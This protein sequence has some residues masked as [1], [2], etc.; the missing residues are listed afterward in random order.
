MASGAAAPHAPKGARIWH[1]IRRQSRSPG[2]THGHD[3]SSTS[4]RRR[5]CAPPKLA[6]RGSRPAL[7]ETLERLE[8]IRPSLRHTTWVANHDAGNPKTRQ[9]E[10]HGHAMVVIGIDGSPMQGAG[11]DEE[12]IRPRPG[13]RAE[14]AEF[15]LESRQSIRLLDA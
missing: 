2:S 8:V 12:P 7:L 15:P 11:L 13:P 5:S 6:T 3:A 10:R 4:G 1:P 9:G 14:L